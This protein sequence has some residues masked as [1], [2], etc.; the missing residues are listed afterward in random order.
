[1]QKETGRWERRSTVRDLLADGRCG[2]EVLDFLSSM[3]AETLLP[4]LEES[5]AGSN[6]SE[7]GQ[8]EWEEGLEAEKLGAE[9]DYHCSCPPDYIA[10]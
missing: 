8:Q 5:D 2:Q 6:V 10:L 4:P 7:A 3:D 1:V 9:G